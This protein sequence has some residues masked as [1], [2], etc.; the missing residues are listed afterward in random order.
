LALT[1]PVP[2]HPAEFSPEVIDALAPL[3]DDVP[4]VFDPFAGRGRRLGALGHRLGVR[5]AGIDI[6]RYAGADPRVRCGDARNAASYPDE[7]FVVVTSPVYFANRISSDYVN[8]PTLTTKRN[9]R[10]CYGMSLGRALHAGNLA[11]LCRPANLDHYI[12]EHIAVAE[13]WDTTAL[14]NCDSPIADIWT[15]ILEAAG[16]AVDQII[17]VRTRRY[18]GPANSDKRADHEVVTV[19]ELDDVDDVRCL[20]ARCGVD[21]HDAGEYYMVNDDVWAA[22]VLTPDLPRLHLCIGCLEAQLH[23]RL[24]PDDFI[25]CPLN[26]DNRQV[27]SAR[28]RDRLGCP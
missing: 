23:R 25:D 4:L 14:V 8:G 13:H 16:F 7:P 22:A 18:R 17:E 20:C 3:L 19:A 28:L 1:G 21:V 10:R 26:A 24:E 12:A 27:G 5:F 2:P 15:E 6:E 9:G 11:R